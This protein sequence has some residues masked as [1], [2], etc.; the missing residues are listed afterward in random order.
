MDLK[1]KK[2]EN[3]TIS[4]FDLTDIFRMV[5][6]QQLHNK[7]CFYSNI[8][9]SCFMVKCRKLSFFEIENTTITTS[10]LN[11]VLEFLNSKRR[12]EKEIQGIRIEKEE[13]TL[14]LCADDMLS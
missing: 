9:Q 3:H 1:K 6:L 5:H 14:S 2:Q 8:I 12:Q 7:Y 13:D 4:K 10:I 11:A